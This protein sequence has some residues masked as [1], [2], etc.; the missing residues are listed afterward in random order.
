[1]DLLDAWRTLAGYTNGNSDD[2]QWD[3]DR[4]HMGHDRPTSILM[5]TPNLAELIQ[6]TLILL[7]FPKII[8]WASSADNVT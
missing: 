1:M 8:P 2:D 6:K 4:Q 7:S 3:I 5:I